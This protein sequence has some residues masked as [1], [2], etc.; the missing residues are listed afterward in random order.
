MECLWVLFG[1][2]M[3]SDEFPD[4][5]DLF[6]PSLVRGAIRT[7]S[8]CIE[9]LELHYVSQVA[10]GCLKLGNMGRNFFKIYC[11]I[12]QNNNNF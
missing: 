5:V 6:L 11:T 7:N 8:M 10:E 2:E 9:T 3:E 1:S 12:S 4:T